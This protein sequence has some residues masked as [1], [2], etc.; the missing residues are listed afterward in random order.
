MTDDQILET[1]HHLARAACPTCGAVELV[2][3]LLTPV[4]TVPEGD[5]PT[6]RVQAKSKPV[7]HRCPSQSTL[8]LG[9][10]G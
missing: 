8:N 5:E 7:P 3:V 9:G 1:G 6:L 4:L 2:A 10:A